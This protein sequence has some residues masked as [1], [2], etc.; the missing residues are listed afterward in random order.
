MAADYTCRI[1]SD[2]DSPNG[3]VWSGWCRLDLSI[4]VSL[5]DFYTEYRLICLV[6]EYV[7][8]AIPLGGLAGIVDFS[9]ADIAT[10]CREILGGLIYIHSKLGISH[11]SVDCS[12]VL[13]NARG[14]IQ[15]GRQDLA[16]DY[17]KRLI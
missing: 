11:G 7:H 4:S 6:Y 15:L 5:T 3:V 9:E 12:N 8:L 10:V 2:L 16:L 14:E 13:L 17:S 1:R